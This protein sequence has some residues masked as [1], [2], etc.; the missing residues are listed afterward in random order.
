[1]KPPSHDAG[2]LRSWDS[3]PERSTALMI[4][5][6]V[7]AS[8]LAGRTVMRCV[9]WP[10]VLYFYLT[11]KD[12]RRASKDYL[13]RVLEREPQTGD[14][15]RHFHTFATVFI[16]RVYLLS[17]DD[18]KLQI[19]AQVAEEVMQTIQGSRG[20][21]LLVAHFGSFEALRI[22]GTRRAE[23]PISI[24]LDRQVGRMAMSLLEKLNPILASRIIDASRRG[25][26][27]ML[28]IKQAIE[29]GHIVGIM[30]DRAR[31]DERFVV[32]RFLGGSIRL[33]AGPWIVAGMLG[34][35]V[36]LG[37][38][39]YRGGRSYQCQLELFER[40]IELPRERREESLQRCAQRYADR[41]EE[42]VRASPFNWFNFHD[43]WIGE[44]SVSDGTAA[45]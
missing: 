36:V 44:E 18:Q 15:L 10:I 34:I 19:E 43:Y 14:V 2:G 20:C 28:D 25:P 4:T 35:P 8:R 31:A 32:V 24:V 12:A 16:D 37:F 41:L 3:Y 13:R 30:A 26:D 5:A 45:H 33:P 42:H 29:A 22:K 17:D 1:M 9:L 27:L 23:A 7:N 6:L 38:G 40:R 39:T 11:A 21:L